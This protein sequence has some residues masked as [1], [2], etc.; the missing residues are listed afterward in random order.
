M[1]NVE[2]DYVILHKH[3]V[4][5]DCVDLLGNNKQIRKSH[6][7]KVDNSTFTLLLL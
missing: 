6:L 1:G 7:M 5:A 4:K 2:K 3:A